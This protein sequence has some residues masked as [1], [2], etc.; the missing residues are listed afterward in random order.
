[1]GKNSYSKKRKVKRMDDCHKCTRWTCDKH[2]RNKV[3]ISVN[4]EDKI[5]FIKNGL[6]KESLDDII[7]A[8][9]THL[10]G[11]IFSI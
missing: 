1:M 3:M 4:Q 7:Q 10:S 9:K 2:F 5:H 11:D 8:L 6:S